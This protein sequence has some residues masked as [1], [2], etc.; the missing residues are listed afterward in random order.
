MNGIVFDLDGT[1]IE[2]APA[3]CDI[4]N[5]LMAE[6]DLPALDV[7][8]TRRYIGNGASRFLE[9]ALQARRAHSPDAFDT[10]FTRFMTLYDAAPPEANQPMPGSGEAIHELAAAGYSL[11]I[12]TNKPMQPTRTLLKSFGWDRLFAAVVAGDTLPERKPHPEPLLKATAELGAAVTFYVG[13]SEV[14]AATAEAAGLPFLLFA[15]GYRKSPLNEIP[16]AASFSTFAELKGLIE[17]FP[18]QPATT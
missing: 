13:D 11:A 14:D 12:C 18:V 7:A 10:Q 6:L 8:E 4:A 16:H 3:I 9:Q 1:L 5:G 2:S 15:E 17:S